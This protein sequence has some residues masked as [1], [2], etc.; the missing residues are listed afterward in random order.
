MCVA[1]VMTFQNVKMLIP[2]A[3]WNWKTR[4]LQFVPFHNTLWVEIMFFPKIWSTTSL[5]GSIMNLAFGLRLNYNR[6]NL[7]PLEMW[8]IMKHI[9]RFLT[10]HWYL[11]KKIT[12]IF[13]KSKGALVSIKSRSF[14]CIENPF[15]V[16][17]M[18][19][20]LSSH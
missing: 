14:T 15:E 13:Q 6:S 19:P 12:N 9:T 3:F 7:S 8:R 20:H 18:Y 11:N 4:N 5:G 1:K 2:F 10:T 16:I 17:K